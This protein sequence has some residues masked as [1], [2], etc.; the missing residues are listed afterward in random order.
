MEPIYQ[1]EFE[2]NGAAVDC[3]GR[4]KPSMVLFY[5][6]EVAGQHFAL[7]SMDYDS[8]REKNLFWAITRC[9]VQILRL[10]HLGEKLRVE[11]WPMPT[12]RVA[13]PR[14]VIAYDEQGRE[15]FKVM[16][17]WVLM[18]ITSRAMVLPGKSGISVTGTLRG[19]ELAV[20]GSIV[21]KAMD[22][23]RS[24]TVC[25]TD[26]DRNGHMNNTRYLDWIWD[27]LPSEFHAAHSFREL[28]IC[29]HNEAR[30]GQQLELR[31]EVGPD[32]TLQV[33]AFRREEDGEEHRV[34]SAKLGF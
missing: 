7:L 26:L 34:F 29:Y 13:Y 3:Y 16:S 2:I 18:D 33:D 21:S 11:T 14:F 28:T 27:L 10:P 24:R 6:Q 19:N 17:L 15:V 22:N 12:T 25:F 4:L 1:Q 9:K 8:L 32:S 23:R 31:W 5:S 20:P 30:E